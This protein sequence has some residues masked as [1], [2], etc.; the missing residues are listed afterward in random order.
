[1]QSKTPLI[2]FFK[3]IAY[4][5]LETLIILK[6][7]EIDFIFFV[8]WNIFLENIF[9]EKARLKLPCTNL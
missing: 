7:K 8:N 3:Y 1:M 6:L 2:N 9:E 4:F 5:S